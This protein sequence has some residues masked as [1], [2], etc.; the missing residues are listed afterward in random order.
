LK[1]YDYAI[2][3][4]GAAG[5]S[6][7]LALVNS[8]LA[9]QSIL[10]V[11]KEA[12]DNNDRTWCYWA[13]QPSA[14][15]AIRHAVWGEVRFTSHGLDKP[16][17]LQPYRYQMVR[18]IDFY[19]HA[20]E[21]LARYPN[22]RRVQAAVDEVTE[23]EG[24]VRFWAGGEEFQA[25]WCFDSRFDPQ[26]L[27]FDPQRYLTI[28][29]HFEGWTV[30]TDEPVFD[31]CQATL[32][33]LRTEQRDGLCFY[34]VLPFTPHQALVEYTV[35]SCELLEEEEYRQALRAYLDQLLGAGKYRVLHTEEGVIPMTDYVFP[36]RL[37]KHR[38]AIGTRGGRVKAS[39]GYA[40]TRIQAD[41]RDIVRSLMKHQH[42]FDLPAGGPRRRFYDAL[43]LEILAREPL[44]G[45]PIFEAMFTRNPIG[46]IFRFLDEQSSLLEDFLLIASLPPQPFLRALGRWARRSLIPRFRRQAQ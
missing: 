15:D 11:E 32:F 33:D 41:T 19:R 4:G 8:P 31:P 38:L 12:K 14:F 46:R 20:R 23:V 7:A 28:R 36:R 6:L 44:A 10:V 2:L 40:F 1:I 29:Q 13:N 3:G 39:S 35:F 37:G 9:D 42:P 5:L 34:Y 16:I 21:E 17:P 25:R 26:A 45:R 18:G 24:G 30:E 22:V 43:L 27:R